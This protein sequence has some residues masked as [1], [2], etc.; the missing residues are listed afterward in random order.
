VYLEDEDADEPYLTPSA[1]VSTAPPA[2]PQ[3]AP[4]TMVEAPSLRT[5]PQP[6]P[7]GPASEVGAPKTGDGETTKGP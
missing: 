1:T 5:Q 3:G 7:A 6:A 4:V 2:A